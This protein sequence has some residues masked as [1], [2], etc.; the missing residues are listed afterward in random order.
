M[1]EPAIYQEIAAKYIRFA[2]NEARGRSPLYEQLALAVADDDAVLGLL[3]GLPAEKRQPNLI[4]ASVRSVC[5]M[6][7]D[8]DGLLACL[9]TRFK[10]IRR[11]VMS[12]RTQTN[13]PARCA[14]LLPLL[15]RLPQ[16]LALLEVGAS[17]GLCLMPDRYAYRF[18]DV[19]VEPSADLGLPVPRVHCAVNAATPI[20]EANIEVVWRRGM[21]LEPVDVQDG[22]Q[23][24]WLESLVWPGEEDRLQELKLA[25]DIARVDP[26]VVV[27]GDLRTDLPALASEAPRDATLV[28]FHSAVLAYVPSE[29]E[30]REFAETV[31]KT[32]AVWVA[33]ESPSVLAKTLGIDAAQCLPGEFLLSMNDRAVGATDPHGQSLRWFEEME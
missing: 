1:H 15:A 26:P 5:G 24:G 11:V 2:Q 3:A 19:D 10:E 31:R 28:I 27:R 6:P 14:T 22:E 20:P 8:G 32:G 17:A 12:R 4:F 29:S 23:V 16:P 13:V 33:N 30:R 25:V 21:D 18:N 9:T 7:N